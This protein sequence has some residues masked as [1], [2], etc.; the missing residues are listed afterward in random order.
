[1]G[2][3]ENLLL[4][5]EEEGHEE[6]LLRCK[7]AYDAEGAGPSAIFEY[8]WV[9]CR[10]KDEG[11][12]REGI[13]LLKA[14]S[15]EVKKTRGHSLLAIAQAY[16]SLGEYQLARKHAHMLI[17]SYPKADPERNENLRKG[18]ELHRS[19]RTEIERAGWNFL[20]TIWV[21]GIVVAAGY[22]VLSSKKR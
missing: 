22:V 15:Y 13:K 17:K 2:L 9:L 6:Q 11:E 16:R 1:M 8:G 10:S 12:V 19:L 14:L 5:E 4:E 21:V 20:G 7:T 18:I 3:E